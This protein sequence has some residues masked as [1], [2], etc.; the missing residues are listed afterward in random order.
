LPTQRAMIEGLQTMKT[1]LLSKCRHK[2]P[3]K[4]PGLREVAV[5]DV[6]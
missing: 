5:K 4:D 6:A 3:L 2:V 1:T